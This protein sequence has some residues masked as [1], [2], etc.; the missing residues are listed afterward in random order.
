MVRG[1]L[2]VKRE[3]VNEKTGILPQLSSMLIY[4]LIGMVLTLITAYVLALLI[5]KGAVPPA[6]KNITALCCIPGVFVSG[7][8]TARR[9][10]RRILP[11]GLLAGGLFLILLLLISVIFLPGLRTWEGFAGIL[12]S[13]LVGGAAG[14]LCAIGMKKH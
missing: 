4:S 14:A 8:L 6:S 11:M 7:F 5:S 10:G 1:D 3:S 9:A 2:N 13:C 12:A